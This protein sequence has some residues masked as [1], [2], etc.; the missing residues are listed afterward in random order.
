MF[1]NGKAAGRN[2][3]VIGGSAGGTE[4]LLRILPNLPSDLPAAMFVVQ[5]AA[6]NAP[7]L[8]PKILENKTRLPIKAAEHNAQITEG[9]I[10]IAQPNRHLMLKG[11]QLL[12]TGGPRENG[13]RPAIDPLFRSAAA[14][15]GPRVIG[16]LLSGYL[17]DG[18]S[19][20]A[21]I[22]RCGGITVVQDPDDA[23][24]PDLP[25]NALQAMNI[26]HRVSSAD[27]A[28][29]LAALVKEPAGEAAAVP[30][31]IR[32]EVAI[33]E[34]A[35]SNEARAD[36]I[37]ELTSN[38]C[39]DCGGPLWEV[40]EPHV[41]RFRCHTGHAYTAQHLL[42]SQDRAAE[43]ALYSAYRILEDRVKMLN[44]IMRNEE[45]KSRGTLAQVYRDRAEE[46]AADAAELRRL[47]VRMNAV[48]ARSQQIEAHH[49]AANHEPEAEPFVGST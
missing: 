25:R 37:G 23:A 28:A 33:A 26:D 20:L 48:D 43:R 47:I 31:D 21:A 19:G 14:N 39:P 36:A 4:A 18:V 13:F 15:F 7:S 24:V 10:H 32:L 40:D 46:T 38:I 45:Q 8:L 6:A 22:R 2:I 41:T 11:D 17:D 12:L 27:M 3:I 49:S 16:V 30:E 9:V 34:T 5:H 29:R 1:G 44:T 42:E 35:M